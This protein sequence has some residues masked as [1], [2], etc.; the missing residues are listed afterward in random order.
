VS[1]SNQPAAPA[2]TGWLHCDLIRSGQA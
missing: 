2:V 1:S